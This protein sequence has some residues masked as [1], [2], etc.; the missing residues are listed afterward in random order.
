MGYEFFDSYHW[1]SF[2]PFSK[3]VRSG[4]E[5]KNT[6]PGVRPLDAKHLDV[7]DPEKGGKIQIGCL[8]S[9][10]LISPGSERERA[11]KPSP[12]LGYW[13]GNFGAYLADSSVAVGKRLEG[14]A[15]GAEV[16]LVE[17]GAQVAELDLRESKDDVALGL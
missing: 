9:L 10:H 6:L 14:C 8:N 12:L 17:R 5:Y 3:E 2:S 7:L 4:L 15:P 1:L 11:S 16:I 13:L